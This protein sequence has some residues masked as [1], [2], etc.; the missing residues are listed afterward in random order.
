[1]PKWPPRWSEITDPDVRAAVAR[2]PRHRFV[3]PDQQDFAYEDHPLPIGYGQTI[4]QPFVVALMTQLLK[5][6]PAA[7]VLEIGT[8]CGYQT[9]ILAELA[10]EVYSVEVIPELAQGAENRLRELG[11]TNIHIRLGDGWSGWPEAA[12]FDG[13]IVTAAAPSWPAP[14]IAQLAEGGRLVIPVGPAGWDQGLWQATKLEG[15]LLKR[16]I[17]P[18]RFVPLVSPSAHHEVGAEADDFL[19]MVAYL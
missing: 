17:G 13:I 3:P 1:M 14:L 2:V 15:N 7:K 16:A 11:Y 8:G 18:V 19:P 4:S 9:A 5:L 10:K 6:T 12:P